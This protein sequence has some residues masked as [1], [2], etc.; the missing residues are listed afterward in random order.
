MAG[1]ELTSQEYIKHHLTNL[2]YGRFED[3]T[4]GFAHG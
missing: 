4:W 2:T 3:G 1:T